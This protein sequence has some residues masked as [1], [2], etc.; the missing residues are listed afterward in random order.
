MKFI[1]ALN[2]AE[3]ITLREAQRHGPCARVRQR[4]QAVL[5]NSEGHRLGEIA[6][7][8]GVH[9][10]T[11]SL[12]LDQWEHAGLR[13]LYDDPRSGRP[14]IYTAPE[15]QRFLELLASEPRSVAQAGA[16]LAQETGK[17]ASDKTF[18]RLLK[19]KATAGSAVARRS[20]GGAMRRRFAAASRS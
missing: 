20:R 4:A 11:V 3:Q 14:L 8:L 7:L 13:G 17:V 16:Q 19:K 6:T 1:A 2:E 10:T 9:R 5:W 18:K 12:W 15:Q